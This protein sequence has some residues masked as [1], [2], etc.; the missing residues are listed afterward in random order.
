MR[1]IGIMTRND[2]ENVVSCVKILSKYF[3]SEKYFE[4]A[5]H[6]WAMDEYLNAWRLLKDTLTNMAAEEKA[7]DYDIDEGDIIV[8]DD[9]DN[10]EENYRDCMTCVYDKKK[11]T[12][13]PCASCDSYGSNFEEKTCKTCKYLHRGIYE[14]PCYDCAVNLSNNTYTHDNYE[15]IE[16][17]KTCDNCAHMNDNPFCGPCEDC[18]AYDFAGWEPIENEKENETMNNEQMK[19]TSP[20]ITYVNQV[21]C[22]FADDT[23]VIVEYNDDKKN[24]VLKVFDSHRA[25]ALTQLLPIRKDFGGVILHISV[26]TENK[27]EPSFAELVEKAM[28]GNPHF[29]QLIK[30]PMQDG[31]SFNYLMFEPEVAQYWNDNLADPHGN[32]STVFADLAQDVFGVVPGTFFATDC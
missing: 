28:D 7:D 13:E 14:E 32:V 26:V 11:F 5:S 1:R 8:V 22:M 15:P 27:I 20:W 18:R 6:R 17:E 4:P 30:V 23:D 10:S 19:I 21:K 9:E 12:E 25:D 31:K 3:D 16:E 29:S 2:Q 24:L